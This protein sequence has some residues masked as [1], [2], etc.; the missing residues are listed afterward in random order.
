MSG[1]DEIA[2][3][4]EGLSKCYRVY[5]RPLDMALELLTR[6]PRHQECWALK[7]V[8][9][10]VRQG[11]VVGV[12]GRNG[13]GKSTL[14]KILAGTLDHSGGNVEIRGGVSA[15]LEIGTGFHPDQTGRQNVFMGG[16]CLGMTPEEIERKTSGII[17]FSELEHVIDQPLKTYS[18]GMKARLAF[19]TAISVE[20]DLLLIDE[21]LAVGDALFQEKSYRRIREIVA[22]GATAFLV[23]HSLSTMYELCDRCMLLSRGELV[24]FGE[25]RVAGYEYERLL[26][27]DRA[28]A[29][30]A[31][32]PPIVTMRPEDV[33]R[34]ATKA[35]LLGFELLDL[36]GEPA[37]AVRQG[38]QYLVR[39]RVRCRE[40]VERLSVSF[41]VD[42]PT[43]IVAYG[44]STA[45]KD[46]E[47]SGRAGDTICVDFT[48][49]C[50][51]QAGV[52][53]LGG[54]VAE[55][56]EEGGFVIHHLVR[57]ALQLDVAGATDFQGVADIGSEV[58]SVTR[59][60]R[61]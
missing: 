39:A 54:G 11:E 57:H 44:T 26:A 14:L 32:K 21:A 15:I 19:A 22:G 50:R 47:I 42:R 38:E 56:L 2:V 17:E 34:V 20:P 8:S 25:A 37:D 23:T 43:G 29:A 36:S 5:S 7:D 13:A 53:F 40:D 35:S 33:D 3:Q 6:G 16:L 60:G 55:T 46:V 4:V 51:L 52:Y 27:E 18:S 9:F 49:P 61:A 59:E 24:T 12:I 58:A 45:S 41:R 28:A 10:S 48:F 31:A 1:D 30:N